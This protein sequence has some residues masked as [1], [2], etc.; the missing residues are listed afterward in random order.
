MSTV[1][2]R[3]ARDRVPPPSVPGDVVRWRRDVLRHAGFDAELAQRLA[4]DP[5][6]GLHDLLSLVDR[7][8][9][10]HLAARIVAPL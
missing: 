10:P 6:I 1:E 5:A 9:P 2:R 4:S 7:G 8:C 3:T